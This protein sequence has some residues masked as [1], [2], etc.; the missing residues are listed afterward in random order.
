MGFDIDVHV[1]RRKLALLVASL[2]TL[3]RRLEPQ[4]A[5]EI[6]QSVGPSLRRDIRVSAARTLPQRGGLAGRVARTSR[7]TV[8][9]G[10]N[11]VRFRT[12][13]AYNTDRLDRGRVMHPVFGNR[14][15]WVNQ[16]I[17]PGWW[18][19]PV[20]EREDDMVRAADD[21]IEKLTRLI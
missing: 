1:N 6:R 17:T 8:S 5:K 4:A 9:A 3:R 11:V 21:A 19:R 15:V 16:F 12:T 20:K 14:K 18:S 13:S 7:T 2:K 10:R